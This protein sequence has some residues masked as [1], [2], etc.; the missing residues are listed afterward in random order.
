MSSATAWTSS[1]AS[2]RR[3]PLAAFIALPVTLTRRRERDRFQ[4]DVPR[5][6]R[7]GLC[8][9][10]LLAARLPNRQRTGTEPRGTAVP[11]GGGQV[12]VD[13][14]PAGCARAARVRPARRR[15]AARRLP[16]RLRADL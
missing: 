6:A 8:P 14:T 11:S 3:G 10:P 16:A 12:A 5:R 1:W 13:G 9:H 15:A 2:D 4:D 7:S